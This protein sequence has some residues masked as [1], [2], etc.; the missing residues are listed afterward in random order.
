MKFKK[1]KIISKCKAAAF[2]KELT[3]IFDVS[4]EVSFDTANALHE[5]ADI[6]PS[7]LKCRAQKKRALK[8]IEKYRLS[9]QTD[10]TESPTESEYEVDHVREKLPRKRKLTATEVTSTLDRCA[11]SARKARAIIACTAS[12]SNLAGLSASTIYR[13]RVR[14]REFLA[15]QI[16]NEF[17]AADYSVVHWDGK[18]LANLT[19]GG[20]GEKVDRVAVLVSGGGK[21]KLLGVPKATSGTGE[22]QANVVH[23]CL[24]EWGLEDKVV[25][26]C[27]DNTPSN[28]GI[29]AGACTLL[30][31]KLGR[32]LLRLA[33][34]HHT[35]ELV[36]K[37]A[38]TQLF[39]KSSTPNITLFEKFQKAWKDMDASK[40]LKLNACTNKFLKFTKKLEIIFH[41]R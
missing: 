10:S 41:L 40:L 29:H 34:R 21:N 39:G 13:H 2:K 12:G 27:F 17:T 3:S 19:D 33:C 31:Q 36:V 15:K 25:G 16:K 8:A 4:A 35:F 11:V 30:E 1:I 23:A 14:N 6:K 18:L 9:H 37:A 28:T 20:K 32:S 26:M 38:Y 24:L 22:S 7:V 5:E